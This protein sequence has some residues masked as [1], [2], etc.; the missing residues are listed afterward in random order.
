MKG[1]GTKDNL[2]WRGSWVTHLVSL[3]WEIEK[4]VLVIVKL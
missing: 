2:R 4:K 1:K 3:N